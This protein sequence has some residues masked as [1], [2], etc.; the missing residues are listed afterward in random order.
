MIRSSIVWMLAKYEF[1]AA[2][3]NRAV[4]FLLGLI[5]ALLIYGTITAYTQFREQRISAT[6][7]RELVRKHWEEMPD[8]HPHRMA[9][10]GY[11]AF[12][13]IDPLS[14]FDKGMDN[15]AG[16]A[17]FLEAHKQNTVNFSEAGLS[18]GM[19]RFGEISQ[20][21]VLQ[22]LL[23]LLLFFIGFGTIATDRENGTLKIIFSQGTSWKELLIGKCLGI[24]F[25][26][27]SVLLITLVQLLASSWKMPDLTMNA[28]WWIRIFILFL[29]YSVYYW[30]IAAMTVWVSSVSS[31]ARLSLVSLIGIWLLL[32][33]IIP[34]AIQAGGSW[35]FPAPSKI[36]FDA[37]VEKELIKKGDSH[38]PND[39]YYKALKD[40]VL[41]A[42]N[43]SSIEDLPFN[44]S[45]F[46]MK[47]GER[48]SAQL[49]NQQM[50]LVL[51]TY[52]KQNTASRFSALI[53]PFIPIRLSSM[54]VSGTDF[55]A[56]QRFQ[57]AA[58]QYRY[59]LAQQM[60][61]WQIKY[62]SNKKPEPGT[63]GPSISRDFWKDFPDFTYETTNWKQA[64]KESLLSLYF[65][66]AWFMFSFWLL[67]VRSKKLNAL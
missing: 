32:G 50:E 51:D 28:D 19:L 40:S 14:L 39:P 22:L 36:K 17:I 61:D 62:I 35:L 44:Y 59:Q 33:T 21:M 5:I 27:A 54:A 10:Y 45:G 3:S 26:G 24:W 12:R 25:I 55:A 29:L 60:N 57:T 15:Y 7:Y 65:L 9:H 16:N 38:D 4:R 56:Y 13:T 2:I 34:R 11:I 53:N 37:E 52:R 49:Y 20:A 66:I 48:I 47:E 67:V 31:S 64:I 23:P 58:E 41:R 46:Q 30:I 63:K 18:T 43:V 1:S 6:Y 8:K 42:N